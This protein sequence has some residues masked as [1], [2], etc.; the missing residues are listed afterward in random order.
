MRGKKVIFGILIADDGKAVTVDSCMTT[1]VKKTI[2]DE[3][4]RNALAKQVANIMVRYDVPHA[5]EEIC[6]KYIAAKG[7]KVDKVTR[8]GSIFKAARHDMTR[9]ERLQSASAEEIAK[10]LMTVDD[11]CEWCDSAYCPYVTDYMDECPYTVEDSEVACRAAC[12]KWL[13]SVPE[14][15]KK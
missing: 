4:A 7:S 2:A 3:A 15:G 1:E 11:V 5:F 12:V 6:R 10:L 14:G 9:L 8:S 13:N